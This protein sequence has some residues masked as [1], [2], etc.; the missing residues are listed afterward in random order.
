MTWDSELYPPP[1]H[2]M[3]KQVH[4]VLGL[5]S[6]SSVPLTPRKTCLLYPHPTQPTGRLC[7][8]V[9]QAAQHTVGLKKPGC[10]LLRATHTGSHI[11]DSAKRQQ[12]GLGRRNFPFLAKVLRKPEKPRLNLTLCT[13]ELWSRHS[14]VT[15]RLQAVKRTQGMTS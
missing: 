7:R 8:P 13:S 9:H 12:R 15:T 5:S 3:S 1:P 2:H 10:L 4:P 11:E 6:S 14:L